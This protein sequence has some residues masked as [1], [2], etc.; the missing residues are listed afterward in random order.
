MVAVDG[1]RGINNPIEY[2]LTSNGLNDIS[3]VFRIQKETGIIF[4]TNNL[5]REAYLPESSAYVLQV[6]V[7]LTFNKI[8]FYLL[9]L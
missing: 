1:D 3:N 5:D 8:F 6:T 4:T 7:G 9:Y 2:S